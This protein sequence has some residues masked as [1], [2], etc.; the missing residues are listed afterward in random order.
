MPKPITTVP[1]V[2]VD[3]RELEERALAQVLAAPTVQ[4]KVAPDIHLKTSSF[5]DDFSRIVQMV[6][7]RTGSVIKIM[8]SQ[9]S[10]TFQC[11]TALAD[12]W[13]LGVSIMHGKAVVSSTSAVAE[14]P[15]ALLLNAAIDLCAEFNKA[16]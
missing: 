14:K 7:N 9:E 3:Y 1:F 8:G 15:Y 12:S 5:L 16:R 6:S 11:S 10:D 4:I 13:C 2:D